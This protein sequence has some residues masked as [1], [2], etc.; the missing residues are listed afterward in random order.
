MNLTASTL[1]YKHIQSILL[2]L[3]IRQSIMRNTSQIISNLAISISQNLAFV[4]SFGVVKLI[5]H[6]ILKDFLSILFGEI[7]QNIT[8]KFMLKSYIYQKYRRGSCA[9]CYILR[10]IFKPIPTKSQ[11]KS[12]FQSYLYTQGICE[13]R[14]FSFQGWHKM[15]VRHK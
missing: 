4:I 8:L 9:I 3:I 12:F 10:C 6:Q 15:F 7:L 1:S 14:I 13:S 5:I 2:S 11:L